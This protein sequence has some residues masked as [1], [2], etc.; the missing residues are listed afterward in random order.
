LGLIRP[1][2]GASETEEILEG[3]PER[4]ENIFEATEAADVQA[5]QP[6]I[7][8]EVV[9]LAL[10]QVGQ[11]LVSLG[12]LFEPVF[13]HLIPGVLVRVILEGQPPVSGPDFL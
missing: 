13:R 9:K 8:V 7:T 3:L 10:F 4:A 5:R 6:G 11:D 1:L 2:P 12:N